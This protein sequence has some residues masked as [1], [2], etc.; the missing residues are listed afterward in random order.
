MKTLPRIVSSEREN[1]TVIGDSPYQASSGR[2][3][4]EYA[5]KPTVGKP[6]R[7]CRCRA[8]EL[9]DRFWEIA[10]ADQRLKWGAQLTSN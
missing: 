9:N 6:P 5:R 2:F 8:L 10:Q 7:C 4:I 3:R 1:G